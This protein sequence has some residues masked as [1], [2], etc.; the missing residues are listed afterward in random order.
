MNMYFLKFIEE[1]FLIL[2]VSCLEDENEFY[3]I[4]MIIYNKE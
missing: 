2:N 3:D 4:L 1:I